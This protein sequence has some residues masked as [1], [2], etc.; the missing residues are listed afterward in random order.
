MSDSSVPPL[1][2]GGF[3]PKNLAEYAEYVTL[4]ERDVAVWERFAAIQNS[5]SGTGELQQAMPDGKLERLIHLDHSRASGSRIVPVGLAPPGLVEKIRMIP[6]HDLSQDL[7]ILHP[8]HPEMVPVIHGVNSIP[9][10]SWV[11]PNHFWMFGNQPNNAEKSEKDS[12]IDL[13]KRIIEISPDSRFR[14]SLRAYEEGDYEVAYRAANDWLVRQPGDSIALLIRA[15]CYRHLNF[16]NIPDAYVSEDLD[17]ATRSNPKLVPLREELDR[18]AARLKLD[19][20]LATLKQQM[21]LHGGLLHDEV[22]A[23]SSAEKTE[24]LDG[25]RSREADRTRP[26][27]GE[28]APYKTYFTEKKY[29]LVIAEIRRRENAGE[30]GWSE[31]YFRALCYEQLGK[32]AMAWQDSEKALRLDTAQPENAQDL[33]ALRRRLIKQLRGKKQFRKSV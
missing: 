25:V 9:G 27:V 15:A 13:V 1:N 24:D 8:E 4:R 19:T 28:K 14:G 3:R 2:A 32:P 17:A 11:D 21:S 6:Y 29:D 20:N 26:V 18:E 22:G 31:F 7:N 5:L 30:A 12:S 10:L 23:K 16:K 33:L